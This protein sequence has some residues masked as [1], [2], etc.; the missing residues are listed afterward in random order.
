MVKAEQ[1]RTRTGTD[2]GACPLVSLADWLTDGSTNA[3]AA[4]PQPYSVAILAA[5]VF[6]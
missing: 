5:S 4:M 2:K 6:T 1:E 3:A